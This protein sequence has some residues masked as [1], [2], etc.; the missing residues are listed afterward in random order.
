MS[1]MLLKQTVK[2]FFT[3][4]NN[5]VSVFAQF[6][7]ISTIF[8]SAVRKQKPN[9]CKRGKKIFG[10]PFLLKKFLIT[11]HPFIYNT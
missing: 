9:A 3:Q 11:V 5:T 10:D 4:I 1:G 8:V 7:F 2:A 6:Y